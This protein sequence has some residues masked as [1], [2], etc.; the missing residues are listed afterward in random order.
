MN[1]I[2][3]G[4]KF[5]RQNCGFEHLKSLILHC[6]RAEHGIFRFQ[7]PSY[8]FIA[9]VL[10]NESTKELGLMSFPAIWHSAEETQQSLMIPK[11]QSLGL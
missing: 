9:T 8:V 10:L 3:L 6:Q 2:F 4:I 5:R 7:P 1:L 11:L